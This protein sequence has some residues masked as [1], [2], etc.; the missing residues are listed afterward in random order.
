VVKSF[1]LDPSAA[2]SL[3]ERAAETIN[4]AQ[5]RNAAARKSHTKTTKRKLLL[6]HRFEKLML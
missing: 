2:K 1:W 3:F 6:Q 4:W 5:H